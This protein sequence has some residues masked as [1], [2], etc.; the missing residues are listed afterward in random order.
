M[1]FLY[2][3]LFHTLWKFTCCFQRKKFCKCRSQACFWTQLTRGSAG[4]PSSSGKLHWNTIYCKD[5]LKTMPLDTGKLFR[6][7]VVYKGWNIKPLKSQPAVQLGGGNPQ[8]FIYLFRTW[9]FSGR[10]HK[11]LTAFLPVWDHLER[12][13][14]WKSAAPNSTDLHY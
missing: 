8:S 12:S 1:F 4:I 2:V 10:H 3:R 13:T 7:L 14:L 6:Y 5:F 11:L 9:L